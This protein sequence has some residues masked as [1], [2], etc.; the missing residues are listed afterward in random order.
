MRRLGCMRRRVLGMLALGGMPASEICASK[1]R[2]HAMECMRRRVLLRALEVHASTHVFERVSNVTR[3]FSSGS[4]SSLTEN[5]YERLWL[6]YDSILFE[7]SEAR[8]RFGRGFKSSTPY[9]S[10]SHSRGNRNSWPWPHL[11]VVR[12]GWPSSPTLLG[13]PLLLIRPEGSRETLGGRGQ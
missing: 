6:R 10:Q 3:M 2:A 7:N 9:F 12:L 13:P 4:I 1:A 11:L 5:P 8:R